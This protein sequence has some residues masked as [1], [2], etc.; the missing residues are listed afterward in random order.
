M[1]PVHAAQKRHISRSSVAVPVGLDAAD[2]IDG[3]GRYRLFQGH[4]DQGIEQLSAG[5]GTCA[6]RP[7]S[8]QRRIDPGKR[9]LQLRFLPEDGP[10]IRVA[11]STLQDS[12]EMGP[13]QCR[14][15]LTSVT[16]VAVKLGTKVKLKS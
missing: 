1:P 6:R 3:G 4:Y 7:D 10:R 9:P 2:G 15:R 16:T 12:F 11:M 5:Q 8:T 14:K 13:S